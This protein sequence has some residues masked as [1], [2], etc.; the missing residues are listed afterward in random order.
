MPLSD[1][2]ARSTVRSAVSVVCLAPS[3]A[4]LFRLAAVL[5]LLTAVQ[6]GGFAA[7]PRPLPAHNSCVHTGRDQASFQVG[8]QT[9]P[10]LI[11]FLLNNI[12]INNVFCPQ[13]LMH[14]VCVLFIQ[15][16]RFSSIYGYPFYNKRLSL[17]GSKWITP[18][19]DASF[20]TT[21]CCPKDYHFLQVLNFVSSFFILNF[22]FSHPAISRIG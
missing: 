11:V 20:N 8:A 5:L 17:C 22:Q 6:V 16:L 12:F 3:I 9:V 2:F 18:R 13:Q 7:P 21:T 19:G 4:H 14:I 10:Q 15:R 1:Y